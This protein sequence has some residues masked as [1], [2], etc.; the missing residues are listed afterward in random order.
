MMPTPRK[1]TPSR[2]QPMSPRRRS[3]RTPPRKTPVKSPM[4]NN[5]SSSDGKEEGIT[6]AVR[7]R[8][9]NQNE[10]N[11]QRVWK[12]LPKYSSVAQTT[13]NGQPLPDRVTGR[14]FFTFDKTFNETV[15]TAEVYD[16]VAKDIV[17]SVVSGLNGTIFAY[18]QTSS[19]K[20]YTMQ[21][22]GSIKEGSCGAGGVVHMAAN[23]IFK[24]ISQAQDRIFL[25]RASFLEIYNEEVRDLLSPN[26]PTL[27]VREDPRRGVFVQS[28][29]EIV[30]NFDALLGILFQGESNRAFA[31][32]AMN[33]R[34]SRSHTIFRITIESRKKG[35]PVAQDDSDE[36]STKENVVPDDDGAVL[37]ST[38]NLV[39]LAG[40][41]SVRHTGATGERQ[42]EGGMINTSL[43]TLSRVIVALGATNQ[44]HIN[45]RDSKLTRILQ[46]S[47]SG[48]ARMAVICCA[49]PSELYLEETRST[50]LFA[51]RAKL[52]KTR[53]QVNEVLDDR[54]IIR[55]LQRELAEARRQ[56]P[57]S[58]AQ[59]KQ[60]KALELRADQAGN[61]AKV[62]EDK[63]IRLKTSILNSG[64]LFGTVPQARATVA[65]SKL[66]R[67]SH[68]KNP[69]A[70]AKKG[71]RRYSEGT[72]EL[73][74]SVLTP[75]R[76]T[77]NANPQTSTKKKTDQTPE[78][79]LELLREALAAKNKL[80]K[81]ASNELA[82]SRDELTQSR[83][84]LAQS[85]DELA[86]SKE[87]ISARDTVIFTLTKAQDELTR[88][89]ETIRAKDTEIAALK[90]IQSA[91]NGA[92]TQI[93][94][95]TT[96][97][98]DALAKLQALEQEAA[99][100]HTELACINAELERSKATCNA[101]SE[102]YEEL[103]SEKE[104]T[105]QK[106]LAEKSEVDTAL[107]T[108]QATH[109]GLESAHKATLDKLQEQ[110]KQTADKE[111]ELSNIQMELERSE[112]TS[113]SL[114]ESYE[115]LVSEHESM[116]QKLLSEKAELNT[117]LQTLQ[118]DHA[119]Q[120]SQ[121]SQ[122]LGGLQA[123]RNNL[124]ATV[125]EK[126][127]ENTTLLAEL[128]RSRFETKAGI[129]RIA[130][131]ESQLCERDAENG[132]L[133]YQLEEQKHEY[134]IQNQEKQQLEASLRCELRTLE[135]SKQSFQSENS[136]LKMQLA[137]S[138][139][140][141]Q[142]L[143]ARVEDM[144]TEV[145]V[146]SERA[147]HFE[148]LLAKQSSD[149]KVSTEA[150]DVVKM[151][152]RCAEQSVSLLQSSLEARDAE[153][154]SLSKYLED[155]LVHATHR[156]ENLVAAKASND[157][158]I[159]QSDR[160]S[161]AVA[162][163]KSQ[164]AEI[165]ND[166]VKLLLHIQNLEKE[167]D[168]ILQLVEESSQNFK[169][170]H[171]SFEAEKKSLEELLRESAD[172]KT[173]LVSYLEQ[174]E[175]SLQSLRAEA[176]LKEEQTKRQL[177]T[178]NE[179]LDQ[180][181][182]DRHKLTSELS[183]LKEELETTISARKE[184]DDKVLHLTSECQA[185]KDMSKSLST[186]V[187]QA[188]DR[189]ATLELDVE[190]ATLGREAQFAAVTTQFDA[191][192]QS[193]QKM[194][195]A[196]TACRDKQE[197]LSREISSLAS[198][199]T[200]LE[201]EHSSALEEIHN[202][203][204]RITELELSVEK[205]RKCLREAEDET[206]V[207][208]SDKEELEE[209]LRE[210]L[211]EKTSLEIELEA[212]VT[213]LEAMGARISELEAVN[214][215]SATSLSRDL[216]DLQSTKKALEK[217]LEEKSLQLV[218]LES[219]LVTAEKINAELDS[220]VKVA[221]QELSIVSQSR[222][223]AMSAVASLQEKLECQD[224][225]I[226]SLSSSK[227]RLE[228]QVEADVSALQNHGSKI[229]E[230]QEALNKNAVMLEGQSKSL[231]AIRSEKD[232]LTTMRDTLVSD[233][234]TAKGRAEVL[235][236]KLDDEK[237][238][239]SQIASMR[240]A[241]A[242]ELET[243]K[244]RGDL[245]E[246]EL[247]QAKQSIENETSQVK[248][249]LANAA[250]RADLL[251]NEL[252]QAIKAIEN[253]T[254][255]KNQFEEDLANATAR[256]GA[257]EN[258]L[259]QAKTSIEKQVLQQNK[260]MEDLA[261]AQE[262]KESETK[263]LEDLR[264]AHSKAMESLEQAETE[265][266]S[267]AAQVE[268][269]TTRM[270]SMTTIVQELEAT[271][272][273]STSTLSATVEQLQAEK[274][275][276]TELVDS[277]S[278]D[279]SRL[280][281][282]LK[283]SAAR[284]E[285]MSA[286]TLELT[287]AV[288]EGELQIETATN[289]LQLVQTERENA[290]Q[291]LEQ[292]TGEKNS[293]VTALEHGASKME[294]LTSTA[295]KLS[296]EVN[297][298]ET[299]IKD[300]E[301]QVSTVQSEVTTLQRSLRESEDRNAELEKKTAKSVEE[302]TQD[303]QNLQE[304]LAKSRE[305]NA[306]ALSQLDNTMRELEKACH[307]R[308][309]AVAAIDEIQK[310]H[311]GLQVTM[312]EV[313]CSK[314]ALEAANGSATAEI[315]LLASKI[316]ELEHSLSENEKSLSEKVA[317]FDAIK[318]EKEDLRASLAFSQFEL[319]KAVS[320][321]ESL[322]EK[323]QAV[324]MR[325]SDAVSSY[326]SLEQQHQ[327]TKEELHAVHLELFQEK[328]AT[329]LT[330]T[331]LE[332][333]IKVANDKLAS[334]SGGIET[335]EGEKSDI[336]SRLDQTL[337]DLRKAVEARDSYDTKLKDAEEEA[338]RQENLI[339]EARHAALALEDELAEKEKELANANHKLSQCEEEIQL[340]IEESHS[341]STSNTEIPQEFLEKHDKLE[342]DYSQTLEQLEK[343]RQTHGEEQRLLLREGEKQIKSLQDETKELTKAKTE[344]ERMA[345]AAREANEQ[346]RE[347][348]RLAAKNINK[349]ST[350]VSSLK[351][352]I[353][354]GKEKLQE[355]EQ[356]LHDTRK[357]LTESEA[358]S[359]AALQANSQYR[360]H[361]ARFQNEASQQ[362]ETIAQLESELQDVKNTFK[363]QHDIASKESSRLASRV[364]ALS[365]E[366]TAA[367]QTVLD[368]K[369][370]ESNLSA[371]VEAKTIESEKLRKQVK[372]MEPHCL[373][374]PQIRSLGKLKERANELEIQNEKLEQEIKSL[375]AALAAM[376]GESS[377][378][379]AVLLKEYEHKI[380]KLKASLEKARS[381]S[382]LSDEKERQYQA[383]LQKASKDMKAYRS[384]INTLQSQLADASQSA[385]SSTS[386]VE[387]QK[388][389]FDNEA[390]KTKLGKY[391]KTCQMYLDEKEEMARMI[392][393]TFENI[394]CKG[395]DVL[396]AVGALCDEN[397]SLKAQFQSQQ[398]QHYDKEKLRATLSRSLSRNVT[399][400]EIAPCI[401]SVLK[402]HT[403]LLQQE[404]SLKLR[405]KEL[406][407]SL[408]SNEKEL[409]E[410]KQKSIES[411]DAKVAKLQQENLQLMRMR[412]ETGVQLKALREENSKLRNLALKESPTNAAVSASFLPS[413]MNF[414]DN[415]PPNPPV[416]KPSTSTTFEASV[417]VDSLSSE[418]KH[419][420]SASSSFDDSYKSSDSF[421]S[422]GL[423][424]ATSFDTE[425]S[426]SS[427][428]RSSTQIDNGST[429]KEK[430]SKLP[431]LLPSTKKK[432][433]PPTAPGLGEPGL[434]GEDSKPECNQS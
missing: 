369:E 314:V 371:A 368:L 30:T 279:K 135:E 81:E 83:D 414:Q 95:L 92:C 42:K 363:E 44:T 140:E 96:A 215:E 304:E 117:A 46:P 432:K 34:S 326:E 366:L 120:V 2:K 362:Q 71:K 124:L 377:D 237:R 210:A 255:L 15:S 53:A 261:K 266:A 146:S 292:L 285:N 75:K 427:R 324:D 205:S 52:V 219:D 289:R 297:A 335:L 419:N 207:L 353:Q 182:T 142:G 94:L 61:A 254:S 294:E 167:R 394:T 365:A 1:S 378:S 303:L 317:S 259:S 209:N 57:G 301:T 206:T 352:V 318:V 10:G 364:N 227:A 127:N 274:N 426:N 424:E 263:A 284:I 47:L 150:S 158:A 188:R 177:A 181:T 174:C 116:K 112:A 67:A 4:K 105:K 376:E 222:E 151:E 344:A 68:V 310:K 231:E 277:L 420:V 357:K 18:G 425:S 235:E 228:S 306:E 401:E 250:A 224:K 110:T 190:N 308:D 157:E 390:L 383:A 361:A 256:A 121:H 163:M 55:R 149:H 417:A 404:E 321:R 241:L 429:P 39:D 29:E 280:E 389:N 40:S 122:M 212:A 239:S 170:A 422:A 27:Q 270:E 139:S 164:Q 232:A 166:Y 315:E 286:T 22:S 196:T 341:S 74:R 33:E 360:N 24:N 12:V 123:E 38:L 252:S 226:E 244:A 267:L 51:Q 225:A 199:K 340:L 48:N 93:Q 128:E 336:G 183:T 7:M 216:E 50:L 161:L 144:A 307:G 217:S 23:D 200:A 234:E 409:E 221:Q 69:D 171:E 349:L 230:L 43:L 220:K 137:A 412:K 375:K 273:E 148:T 197:Q 271:G 186:T 218:A 203:C 302:S 162:D 379:A 160:L 305:T 323:C 327:N 70:A 191:A 312:N 331:K 381:S 99:N 35:V 358:A 17:T 406:T 185:A 329:T 374:K 129:E 385:D 84:E 293:L 31:S 276:L 391:V 330:I 86:Q 13:K 114:S 262:A 386:A 402:K 58:A 309:E 359:S 73:E 238:T 41:E 434:S 211:S 108:L 348:E 125:T 311:N 405:V 141:I 253:E 387:H 111:T 400:D 5:S 104:S 388:T 202:L 195:E 213:E 233:L 175:T 408:A 240:D 393:S 229:A 126:G 410:A 370:T 8:P 91:H 159:Q 380:A 347:Q 433:V 242:A 63:L 173:L 350:E 136:K 11:H 299:K 87:S 372:K 264:V 392:S 98:E 72:L 62:A 288:E 155:V 131:L 333:E 156:Q 278:A 328:T 145:A 180:T 102:S 179:Q 423:T 176:S 147:A 236:G 247:S 396:D 320:S 204:A 132:V 113:K 214:E 355:T 152:L 115:G 101:L 107:Q 54:S 138:Q 65:G 298:S 37:I 243:A 245:L 257:L 413:Q 342:K 334:L 20:T 418:R 411:R 64:V 339:R 325:L 300:L 119:T 395:D 332:H 106:L 290:M 189:I 77:A 36:E 313:K 187:E 373:T 291:T 201:S 59:D 384:E 97:H 272:A 345:Y 28:K 60:L 260:Q 178:L 198:E 82:Q 32:T 109:E 9:L 165:N 338:S 184:S 56:V 296:S 25:V 258:E 6:V 431:S 346:Y 118:G 154:A 248:E 281:N 295:A 351:A 19:G 265:R 80:L 168:G 287:R 103:V 85:R 337:E 282:E 428:K 133:S 322:E 367:K 88:S 421:K 172:D 316:R 403:K 143:S 169:S 194:E 100:K 130:L 193:L 356:K 430:K 153:I 66:S 14:T 16:N 283:E 407:D 398:A 134:Q 208:K 45:F 89:E 382:S 21:G 246:N 26:S 223:E 415:A 49:T 397:I 78:S 3:L 268:D 399:D 343:E 79:E 416:L 319:T 269:I 249:D 192:C 251:E 90:E 275:Q 354:K 76:G